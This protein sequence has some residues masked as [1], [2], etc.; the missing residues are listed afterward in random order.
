[1]KSPLQT[2]YCKK[3]ILFTALLQDLTTVKLELIPKKLFK[4]EMATF[5]L[6]KAS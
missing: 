3:D 5:S 6:A 1:M 2:H 4:F